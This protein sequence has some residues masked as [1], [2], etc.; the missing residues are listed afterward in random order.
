V[1]AATANESREAIALSFSGRTSTMI[2]LA[3][4][5]F[6]F[7]IVTLTIYRF[8]GR[9][10][11]RRYLWSHI[12]INGE[13]LEYTGTGRELCLGF[14]VVVLLIIL[15]LVLAGSAIDL[16]LERGSPDQLTAFGGLY[17]A[18]FLLYMAGIYQAW[19]YRLSRTVWRGVRMALTGSVASF[20]LRIALLNFANILLLGWLTPV[21]DI[22]FL[23]MIGRN[24]WYG[25][26]RFSFEAKARRLYGPFAVSYI[27]GLLLFAL[28]SVVLALIMPALKID[29][30]GVN[31]PPDP[32]AI[33]AL[34]PPALAAF[35]LG[36][37]F[38]LIA[39]IF[40]QERRL[41]IFGSAFRLGALSFKLETSFWSY[42]RLAV[43]N[44]LIVT[45][46]L[47][48]GLPVAELRT[49]RYIFRRL[50]VQGTL[51]LA[52][53]GHSTGPRPRIGEGLAE[54][55]GLGNI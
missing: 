7:S 8:W 23:R 51:D 52:A 38:L 36:L 14:L 18:L 42:L 15:P 3:L 44:L 27:V 28:L 33:A 37:L 32:Q 54:A 13:P 10:E 48:V 9:T 40:Y 47:G 16:F 35:L 45:L 1:S 55:F 12:D 22:A 19:R 39:S 31:G 41:Q 6:L 5:I 20:S 2:G 11:V 34:L 46:T 29:T 50:E 53:I 17:A 43:G 25:D 4:K 49:F 24:A 26:H 21:V 30:D